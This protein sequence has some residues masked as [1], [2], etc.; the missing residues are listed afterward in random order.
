MA[1]GMMRAFKEAGVR[2]PDDISVVGFDDH[3]FARQFNPPLTTVRQ[4]F[5]ALGRRCL[6][7]LLNGATDPAL[8]E[9][10]RPRLLVRQSTRLAQPEAG[11]ALAASG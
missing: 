10:I 6:Q 9:P 5:Q 2:V 11:V 7:V 3:E 4:D 8:L 1:L